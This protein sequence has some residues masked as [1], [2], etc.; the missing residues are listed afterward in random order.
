MIPAIPT[1]VGTRNWLCARCIAG[2]PHCGSSPTRENALS[3]IDDSFVARPM[4]HP[5]VARS[6]PKYQL[7]NFSTRVS[8]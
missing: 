4:I 7:A 6:R 2:A 8:V 1:A 3:E 5:T